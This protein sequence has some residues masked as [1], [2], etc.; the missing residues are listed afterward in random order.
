M[1]EYVSLEKA[2]ELGN[3]VLAEGL[4]KWE[5]FENSLAWKYIAERAGHFE[6]ITCPTVVWKK[7][8]FGVAGTAY[9]NK[10]LIEMN[11]NYLHSP[12]AL[13]F[14]RNTMLHEL[15]HILNGYYGG[16]NHDRQWKEICHILGEDG[17]RCHNYRKPENAPQKD[18]KIIKCVECGKEYQVTNYRYNRYSNYRCRC[19]G[20]LVQI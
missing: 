6:K 1:A 20:K 7:K 16:R 18:R 3:K 13:E 11:S 8:G 12:D 17:E 10:N 9:C 19:K 2:I 14:I 5:Q 15:A 4:N